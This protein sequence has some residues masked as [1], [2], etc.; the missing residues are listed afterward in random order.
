MRYRFIILSYNTGKDG[1]TAVTLR[2]TKNRK[3]KYINTGLRARPE[4]WD[5][6]GDRFVTD[7][8]LVPGYKAYNTRLSELEARVNAVLRDFDS[9]RID[10][11]LN[12]FETEY[13]GKTA[14]G[15]VK[16]YFDKT[17]VTLRETEHI[18]NAI[19]YSR[20]LSMMSLF[21]KRLASRIFSEID[22]RYVKAFDVFLQKRGCRGN[23]RKYYLKALRAVLNKAIQ[24]KEAPESTYPFGKGGF[25]IAA[26][27]E[28][29]AKRHLTQESMTRLKTTAMPDPVLEKTRRLFLFMYYCYGISFIDAAM[30]TRSNLENCNCGTYIVYKRNKTKDNKDSRPIRIRISTEINLLLDWFSSH[31]H[32]YGDYLLPI[33]SVPG[34]SGER[35]YSHIRGRYKHFSRNLNNLGLAIGL[36]GFRLTS[37]VARHTMAMTLQEHHVP[38][39]IISQ[40]LGHKDLST[41]SVYLDSFADSIIDEAA[42]VL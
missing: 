11:T 36:K 19:C 6:A 27:S 12:Q 16:A 21:D 17:V 1:K 13:L 28:I 34:Y 31:T 22:I 42:R 18:G 20:A 41:T 35:L 40:I 5:T 25:N 37:Y 8:R 39:E 23:T 33:V 26:L 9:R 32:L 29:T 4:Q 14:K 7:R 10:W 15:S 30:L 24:D 2:V 3:R 38:R